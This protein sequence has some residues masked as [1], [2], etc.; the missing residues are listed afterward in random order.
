MVATRPFPPCSVVL[1]RSLAVQG[2]KA[3][4]ILV[5][6][7]QRQSLHLWSMPSAKAPGGPVTRDRATAGQAVIDAYSIARRGRIFK[8]RF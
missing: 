7:C 1:I 8:R 4:L 5:D 6:G 2:G 3:S